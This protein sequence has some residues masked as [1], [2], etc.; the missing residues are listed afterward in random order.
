LTGGPQL[1]YPEVRVIWKTSM[2]TSS[3][4]SGRLTRAVRAALALSPLALFPQIVAAQ[5]VDLGNLGDCGFR[6]WI[7]LPDWPRWSRRRV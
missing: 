6:R 7:S 1:S 4:L 3:N 5:D 2:V